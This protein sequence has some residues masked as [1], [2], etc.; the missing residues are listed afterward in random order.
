LTQKNAS[1]KNYFI[2]ASL[3]TPRYFLEHLAKFL[4]R[5]I[6]V[7]NFRIDK[8]WLFPKYLATV[9]FVLG[10]V[11]SVALYYWLDA[12]SKSE[13]ALDFTHKAERITLEIERRFSVPL[14]G[15]N[16][17]KNLFDFYP[18]YIAVTSPPSFQECVDLALSSKSRTA[19]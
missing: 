4:V 7:K 14:Y 18:Q 13:L 2:D 1:Q 8:S 3:K 15:L 17:V 6:L 11:C 16:D 12:K 19:I 10:A 5:T 9:L